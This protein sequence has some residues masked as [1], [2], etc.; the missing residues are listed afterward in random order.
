MVFPLVCH[1]VI[2][3]FDES[4]G[5]FSVLVWLL[6]CEE[7]CSKERASRQRLS[8]SFDAELNLSAIET[9]KYRFLFSLRNMLFILIIKLIVRL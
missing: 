5:L 9:K 4:S 2:N 1:T 7:D 6:P 3:R 8:E